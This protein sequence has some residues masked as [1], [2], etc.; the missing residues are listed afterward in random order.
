MTAYLA[1]QFDTQFFD[2]STVAA[3][4]KL[5]TYDSGTTTPKATYSDQAGVT[6]Q[7]NPIILDAA[8][9]VPGELFLG[10]GEYT[11]T[12]KTAADSL[13]KTWD[14]VAGADTLLRSDLASTSEASK[15]AGGVGLDQSLN[16]A[17]STLGWFCKDSAI[18][19]RLPLLGISDGAVGDSTMGA[20]DGTDDTAA[21]QGAI[22]WATAQNKR[23]YV[24]PTASGKGYRITDG[25]LG[26][27]HTMIS[28]EHCHMGF[29]SGTCINFRPASLKSFFSPT[30]LPASLKDGYLIENLYIEGNCTSAA[31]MSNIGLDIDNIIKST[32]RNCRIQGF[33]TGIRCY[34]T[35]SNLFQMMHPTSNYVQSVLYDGGYA[36]TDNW[37]GGYISNAPTLVQTS[38]ANICI[39]FTGTVFEGAGWPLTSADTAE[40]TGINIVKE[41]YGWQLFGCYGE[42]APL[43]NCATNAMV[44][45]GRDGTTLAGATQITIVGG[46]WGGR[47]AGGVGS[48]LDV[49][50]TDGV[51]LG[52]GAYLTRFTN[53]IKTSSNTPTN[54]IVS[55][56][57]TCTSMS[58]QVTDDTKVTGFYPMGVSGSGSHNQQTYRLSGDQF[59]GTDTACTGAITTSG[60][61]SLTK[62]GIVV[63]LKLPAITGT[64]TAAP[65]FTFGQ[66]IPAKYRPSASIAFNC[67]IK[68]N[69][70][71]QATP[72]MIGIDYLTGNITVYKDAS[73]IANF[74]AAAAAGLTDGTVISWAA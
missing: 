19:V 13:V 8:G 57:W 63:T 73:R 29:R 62:D 36:T 67:P 41:C 18:N 7:T 46:M 12:L 14:N 37:F 58:T 15:G 25:L 45:V 28:G 61:W 55:T 50:H 21:F 9:R 2:G 26:P 48:F 34:A 24:P 38:G 68:D 6:P 20:D 54:S 30:G 56:G 22:T 70:A 32:F 31:G 27:N 71:D 4:Y 59:A 11:L 39:R 72:G 64:A 52:G 33:R 47:N 40:A 17:I 60:A 51:S 10:P 53:G 35:N 74:T 69:G 5:Y 49:D 16:Y 65:S 44:R 66:A 1:P 23:V 42:D 43:T 3:G